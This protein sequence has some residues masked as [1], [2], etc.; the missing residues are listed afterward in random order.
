MIDKETL[1]S[2]SKLN[3]LR[4]WQQ[5]K[6][7]IQT[8]ALISLSEE[9]L[10]FKGGTYLWFFHGLDRFSED[11]D[12]TATGE[13][14]GLEKK[15]SSD[16]RMFGVEN[17]AK[18]FSE[19]ERSFS[20]RISAKGPLNTSEIDLCHVYVEISKREKVLRN[21]ISM[22]VDVPAYKTPTKIVRGMSLDE[23]AAEKV[24]ATMTRNRARDVYDL[25][26]LIG[27]GVSFDKGLV[28]EKLKYYGL[29]YTPDAFRSRLAEKKKIWKAELGQLVFGEL[30]DA[31]AAVRTVEN[32]SSQ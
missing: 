7:Y 23:V 10:V 9:P 8:L 12:F 27:K 13:T 26:F 5:E 21:T 24:R 29:G 6:H 32:W 4:P 15:V 1:V 14:T 19:D 28:E 3:N 2:F 17:E 16:L 30:G 25:L 11:L 18:V 22:K 20:F 31:D